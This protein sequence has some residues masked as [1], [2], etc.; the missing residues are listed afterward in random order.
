MENATANLEYNKNFKVFSLCT[1]F[2]RKTVGCL[3]SYRLFLLHYRNPREYADPSCV[4]QGV[5]SVTH[6]Q[7]AY[8]S[9]SQ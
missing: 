4:A 1:T 7:N 6:D 2:P 5:C 9:A 8:A 3:F